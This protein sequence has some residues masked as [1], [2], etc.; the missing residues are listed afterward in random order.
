[1]NARRPLLDVIICNRPNS[2][3]NIANFKEMQEL[4]EK[5]MHLAVKVI[6]PGPLE[7]CQQVRLV[8]EADVLLTPHGSQNA[9][10]LFS[11]PSSNFRGFPLPDYIDWLGNLLHAGKV[12]H[13]ELYGTWTTE[14]LGM[15]FQMRLYAVILGWKR[16]FS[17]RGCMN[18]GKRRFLWI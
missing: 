17:V 16:C 14:R 3:R 9:A 5:E 8:A 11:C 7:V 4:L 13:Y 6:E 1:M 2:P 15:P 10:V 12:Y 18:Y